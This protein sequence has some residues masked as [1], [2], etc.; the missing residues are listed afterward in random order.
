MTR[1]GGYLVVVAATVVAVLLRCGFVDAVPVD[2]SMIRGLCVCV[3][4]LRNMSRTHPYRL[5][6]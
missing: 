6:S 3:C 2:V 4:V 5:L 1:L